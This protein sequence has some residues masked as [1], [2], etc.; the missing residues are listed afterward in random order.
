MQRAEN[1]S[2]WLLA[3][4]FLAGVVL[5]VAGPALLTVAMS[6]FERKTCSTSIRMYAFG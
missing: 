3:A 4:P 6:L 2:L 5:L 1:R